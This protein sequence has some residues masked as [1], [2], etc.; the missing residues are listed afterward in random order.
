MTLTST[1]CNDEV[2]R[3]NRLAATWCNRTGPTRPLHVVNELPL[4]HVREQI[5]QRSARPVGELH[6]LRVAVGCGGGLV[7]EP[8][9]ARGAWV[10]SVD[11][12]P[13]ATAF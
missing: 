5:A 2:A 8:L 9:A 11:G 7:C 10:V 12:K 13:G 3:F 4:N 1:T 6:G